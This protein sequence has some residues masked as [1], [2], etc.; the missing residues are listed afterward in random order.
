LDERNLFL[1]NESDGEALNNEVIGSKVYQIQSARENKWFQIKSDE[2][3]LFLKSDESNLFLKNESDG[4]AL[5]DEFIGSK[6]YQIRSAWE[7]KC[8]QIK[9]DERNL[10]LKSDESN[11]SLKSRNKHF[12]FQ[13]SSM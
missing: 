12:I 11:L 9:S 10:F 8:G 7:N 4:E 13:Q 6:F 2:R 3:N 5:N 1:K